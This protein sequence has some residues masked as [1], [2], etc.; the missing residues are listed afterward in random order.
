VRIHSAFL[1]ELLN[2]QGSHGQG[3]IFL[4][5]FVK[6]HDFDFASAKVKV[7]KH[8]G[9]VG[10]TT[11]GRIDIDIWDKNDFHIIVENKIYAKDQENQLIRYYNYGKGKR[12][13]KLFYLTLEGDMPDEETSCCD[14]ESQIAL[15]ESEDYTLLSYKVDILE[16]LAACREKAATHPTLREGILFMHYFACAIDGI[17]EPDVAVEE[18]FCHDGK[19]IIYPVISE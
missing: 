17:D 13:F 12:K 11:G 6:D 9:S 18:V 16:W 5:L 4:K 7:E 8:I 3:D 10:Q 1:A 14:K 2:P 19:Y 15:K